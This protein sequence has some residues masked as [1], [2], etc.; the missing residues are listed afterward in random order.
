M[1]GFF[2]YLLFSALI[3]PVFDW[4][5]R[6]YF[7]APAVPIETFINNSAFALHLYLRPV[8]SL[9]LRQHQLDVYVVVELAMYGVNKHHPSIFSNTRR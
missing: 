6:L 2:L 8:Q 5:A 1:G 9:S 7:Y 4:L 3:S